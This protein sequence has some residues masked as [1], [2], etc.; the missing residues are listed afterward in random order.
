VVKRILLLNRI[1]TVFNDKGEVISKEVSIWPFFR[2]SR[3]GDEK[4]LYLFNLIPLRDD[5]LERNWAPLYT[6][7]RYE[8][9]PSG[10]KWDILWGL[11]ERGE[12]WD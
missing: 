7:F 10:K 9:S 3:E 5:G 11:Y 8:R 1:K 6:V 2:Y 12:Q 4:R